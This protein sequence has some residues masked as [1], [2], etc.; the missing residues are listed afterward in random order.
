MTKITNELLAA[1]AEGNVLPEEREAVRQYLS[2][3]P[4]KLESVLF[5]MN[6][7]VN[8]LSS[9]QLS[10]MF[11]NFDSL[12]LKDK[13]VGTRRNIVLPMR[14]MAAK[15]L[16]DNQCV[17]H[18]EGIAIR[19]F[20]LD[21]S[22]DVLSSESKENGW[23]HSKGTALHNIGQLCSLHGLSVCHRYHCQVDDIRQALET[24]K[25]VIAAVDGNE[26]TGDRTIEQ[27]RDLLLGG[28]PNHVVVV[29]SIADETITLTD[30]STT[31]DEDTYPIDLFLD[32]WADS[33][34]YLIIISNNDEYTPQPIN[35]EDVE[36]EADLLDLSEAIAENA[37]E[38]WA[39][40]RC[41]EGWK[42]GRERNDELKEH[43]D[44]LPYNRLPDS[45]KEY[46][47]QMA[48]NTIKLLMKL[49]WE[50]KKREDTKVYSY[51]PART[52][53]IDFSKE[54]QQAIVSLSL[55]L[56]SVDN[57]IYSSELIARTTLFNELDIRYENEK[58]PLSKAEALR[59]Y[60]AMTPEKQDK[61]KS[62]LHRLAVADGIMVSQE[63][64][65]ISQL[66]ARD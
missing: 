34:Y 48:M 44:M 56:I 15:S 41:N 54:E 49:G 43:P 8:E 55:R 47:R 13:R 30:S 60:R 5:V 17:V 10:T 37:H 19:H 9:E 14:A 27:R 65:F 6:D 45:E 63:E 16:V 61:V 39:K 42:Y 31:Q 25:M 64:M 51:T 62:V 58:H 21:I 28:T 18:C 11:H 59:V 50:L 52:G 2:A 23:L 7:D 12:L 20:G 24:G 4:D 1:Y 57:R 46:D 26:L 3:H 22:N 32:A 66:D 33:Q 53:M 35:L 36:L 29:R 40:A 38:V